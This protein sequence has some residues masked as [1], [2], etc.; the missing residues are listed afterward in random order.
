MTTSQA[1]CHLEGC[2]HG[3]G[4]SQTQ[5]CG[6]RLA[7][8]HGPIRLSTPDMAVFRKPGKVGQHLPLP[9]VH[10]VAASQWLSLVGDLDDSRQ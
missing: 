9:T 8:S 3:D 2:P 4:N 10:R 1:G 6:G 7:L 5:T